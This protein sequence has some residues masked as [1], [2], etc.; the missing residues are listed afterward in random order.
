[1]ILLGMAIFF[2]SSVDGD[3]GAL[4]LERFAY[5][6]VTLV[7][8]GYR[9]FK[10]SRFSLILF[11]MI[12]ALYVFFTLFSKYYEHAFGYILNIFPIMVLALLRVKEVPSVVWVIRLYYISVVFIFV[13]AY[14]GFVVPAVSEFMIDFYSGGYEGLSERFQS[15][16]IPVSIFVSHSYAGFFYFLILFSSCYLISCGY[17]KLL[18]FLIVVVCLI[19]MLRLISGTSYFFFLYSLFFL[20]AIVLCLNN[21][22]YFFV[23]L[24]VLFLLISVPLVIY[25][26][27]RFVPDLVGRIIGDSSN[28]LLSRYGGGVLKENLAYIA[29]NPL[30]G[31]GFSYSDKFYYTD[32]DYVVTFLRLGIVGG[33]IYF[34]YIF[35]F[36]YA[37]IRGSIGLF[38]FSVFVVAILV[39]MI[40]MPVS[41]FYRT[42][43]LLLLLVLLYN[44]TS[45]SRD[46]YFSE[47]T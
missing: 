29:S 4:K 34:A 14:L 41:S 22:K 20:G 2:P 30:F 3:F 8:F 44:S 21:K 17:S 43:P 37:S 10:V 28:G 9:Y 33:F 42:T 40:S 23:F 47:K 5:L 35:L 16:F 7:A 45:N 1:M 6:I 18:N 46:V 36:I 11:L 32:S 27:V 31:I 25:L 26:G 12:A 38:Y 13:L 15:Q 39:F 24:K 19:S